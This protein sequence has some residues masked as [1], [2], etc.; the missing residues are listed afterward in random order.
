MKDAKSEAQKEIEEYRQ[1]KET[2]FKSFE[3]Q[4]SNRRSLVRIAAMSAIATVR[5]LLD[6]SGRGKGLAAFGPA[7]GT[8]LMNMIAN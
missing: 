7:H 8:E 3:S 6:S 2:E 1:Q 5:E 4:V